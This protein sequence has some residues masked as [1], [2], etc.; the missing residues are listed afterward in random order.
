MIWFNGFPFLDNKEEHSFGVSVSKVMAH[1]D[2]L[3]ALPAAGTTLRQIERTLATSDFQGFPIVQDF[4]TNA[5]V[6]YI[7]KT[8]LRYAVERAKRDTFVPPDA[9]VVFSSNAG[10]SESPARMPTTPGFSALTPAPVYESNPFDS[11]TDGAGSARPILDLSRFPDF[12]PLAVHPGLPLETVM[13]LFKKLGPRVILVE[14]HGALAGLVTVKDCLKYQFTAEAAEH[15]RE[16]ARL[17]AKEEKLWGWIRKAAG[18]VGSKVAG[19][20]RGRIVLREPGD[21]GRRGAE[22][23]RVRFVVGDED[24]ELEEREE[25]YPGG[26]TGSS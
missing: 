16:N 26:G 15:T 1:S 9:T 7:G 12:T 14:Y 5:L 18:W 25:R 21:E 8:E 10:R 22:E 17:E 11:T 19:W 23:E 2:R 3:T 20:T 6:G 24:T 13:E 4:V